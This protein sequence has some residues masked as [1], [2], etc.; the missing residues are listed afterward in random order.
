[1]RQNAAGDDRISFP[2]PYDQDQLAQVLADADVL[3]VPST[4]YENTPF[5]I[6]EAFEAGVPVVASDLGGMSELVDP[7]Q[8]GYLFEA[9]NATSLATVL[10]DLRDHPDKLAALRPTPPGT[11]ASNYDAFL[12][13]YRGS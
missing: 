2:G 6:L 4:W 7:G 12:A 1:M 13:A 10:R 11:I 9:G 8:N 3:V 5:V